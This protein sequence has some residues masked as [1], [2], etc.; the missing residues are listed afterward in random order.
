MTYSLDL[1]LSNRLQS[2]G[3]LLKLEWLA[4][5]DETSTSGDK[6]STELLNLLERAV[7]G[8]GNSLGDVLLGNGAFRD[9]LDDLDGLS[10]GAAN[11]LSWAREADGKETGVGVGGVDGRNAGAWGG[12]GGLCEE[13]ESWGPLDGGLAAQKSSEDSHLWLV[14]GASS[15]GCGAWEGN[16]VGVGGAGVGNALLTAV[17]LGCWARKLNLWSSLDITEEFANPLGELSLSSSVGDN[18]DVGLGVSRL[19]ELGDALL[20]QVLGEWGCGSWA[21]WCTETAVECDVVDRV[22]GD[23]GGVGCGSGLLEVDGV[24]NLLVVLVC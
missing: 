11:S 12:C 4:T 19:G 2:L 16:N 3:N 13:G 15:E 22:G 24:L 17:V 7:L 21:Q 10:S 20:I 6:S 23:L 8:T 1:L 14:G 5:L 18:S 9:R